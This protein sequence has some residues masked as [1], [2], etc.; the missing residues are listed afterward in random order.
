MTGIPDYEL[1]RCWTAS[2]TVEHLQRALIVGASRSWRPR[3]LL[4]EIGH[5]EMQMG[6]NLWF[7]T[8]AGVFTPNM[9]V[10]MTLVVDVRTQVDDLAEIDAKAMSDLR[11]YWLPRP[12]D[13]GRYEDAFERLFS[14]LMTATDSPQSVA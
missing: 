12:G 9:F 14:N 2:G 4:N 3:V 13:R 5:I 6:S 10:P 8:A 7:H 11:F 1:Q